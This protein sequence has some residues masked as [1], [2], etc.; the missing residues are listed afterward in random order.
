MLFENFQSD[1]PNK[2]VIMA[3]RDFARTEIETNFTRFRKELRQ[4]QDL[5]DIMI[6][7][8][9]MIMEVLQSLF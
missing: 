1:S 2:K 5:R 8:I 4:Y 6:P 9:L 3:I 7:I